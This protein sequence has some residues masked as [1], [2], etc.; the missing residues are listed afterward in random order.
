MMANPT[1]AITL[2]IIINLVATAW[3]RALTAFPRAQINVTVSVL[4]F[5][6]LSPVL[7]VLG[8]RLLNWLYWTLSLALTYSLG[9]A[10]YASFPA[11][12]RLSGARDVQLMTGMWGAEFVFANFVFDF[13]YHVLF[14]LVWCAVHYSLGYHS[15]STAGLILL[16]LVSFG[17]PATSFGYL[18]AERAQS[19]GSAVVQ[20]FLVMYIGGAVTAMGSNLLWAWLESDVVTY[21]SLIVH[22]FALLS[23]LVKIWNEDIKAVQC[24][25][26]E[27]T[28]FR[29]LGVGADCS[30]GIFSFTPQ[31]IGWELVALLAE[32]ILYLAIMVFLTSGYA[33]RGDHFVSDESTSGDED[34]EQERKK[35]VALRQEGDFSA[36]SLLVWNLHKRF[37]T[38]HAVRGAH[39]A[40]RPS[41]CFG[42][43]GVNGAGKTTTFQMLAALIGVSCGDA[44]TAVATLSRNARR[45]QSQISYCFQLG[46]LLDRLNAFEYLCLVGRLRGIPEMELQPMVDGV[47]AVVD[48]TEH[49]SKECGVYSGGNRRKLSIAAALLGLQPFVFLDEPYAGVDVVSRNKISRAIAGIK[50]RSRTTFV[51][52]SHNMDECEF[53]CDRLTIMVGGRMMCL[54]T[55]QHLREKYGQGYRLELLLKRT[56][57]ADAHSLNQA[58]LTIFVGARLK[59]A[60]QNLLSYHLAQRIPWSKLFTKLG[61]LRKNFELEHV[62]VGENTLDDIFLNFAKAQVNNSVLV[63][64]NTTPT[65]TVPAAFAS[66][67]M[68]TPQV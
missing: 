13:I 18:M 50:K 48:L 29:A 8:S 39:L 33:R 36:H 57:A 3:L 20:V 52:T 55:V 41:E 2:P 35:V 46:G 68:A 43:L 25:L 9:F 11:A 32:G 37:G 47:L 42:L 61:E 4:E 15:L 64:V 56:A 62:L 6:A 31:G 27:F 63:A 26:P 49:A 53:S 1:S 17:L 38:L 12:E 44:S 60:H 30:V 34:V 19:S 67:S 5:R 21:A 59:E 54:G 7:L 28:E 10:V 58:V 51:L 45:W 24:K 23:M 16:A 66:P 14:S 65:V 22:P 40:L